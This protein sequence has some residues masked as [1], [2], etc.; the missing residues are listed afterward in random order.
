MSEFLTVDLSAMTHANKLDTYFT[1][2][3]DHDIIWGRGNTRQK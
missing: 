3:C 1:G 2:K